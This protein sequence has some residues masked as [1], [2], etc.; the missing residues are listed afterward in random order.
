VDRQALTIRSVDDYVVATAT[1]RLRHAYPA[2]DPP[3]V[4][5][6]NIDHVLQTIKHTDLQ[7]G[8]WINVIGYVERRKERGIFVQAIVVWGAGNLNLDAYEKA[9]KAR[10]ES[11]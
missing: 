6:V 2:S 7:V 3:K 1:L 11:G 8:A 10:K 5:N 9:A 4:A